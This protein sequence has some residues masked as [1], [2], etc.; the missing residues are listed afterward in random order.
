MDDGEISRRC[1][2]CGQPNQCGLLQIESTGPC[3]C[4][5]VTVSAELLSRVPA[6]LQGRA[7]I[8]KACVA[9]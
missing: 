2:L 5:E 9:E 6:E 3:W 1:P 4:T 7:C 8:C